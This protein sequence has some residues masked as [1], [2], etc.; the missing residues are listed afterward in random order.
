MNKK[1]LWKRFMKTGRIS[2]YLAYQRARD[3]EDNGDF[4]AMFSSELAEEFAQNFDNDFPAME[5]TAAT[6]DEQEY[7]DD[8]DPD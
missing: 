5:P 2:D 6:V 3:R 4:S 1:E 8:D 7:F